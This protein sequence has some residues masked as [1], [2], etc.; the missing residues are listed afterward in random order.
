ML[1]C[2]PFELVPDAK[3]EMVDISF[4][5]SLIILALLSKTLEAG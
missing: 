5:I 3:N 1:Y 2:D 4:Y